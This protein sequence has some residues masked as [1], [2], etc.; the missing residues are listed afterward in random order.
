MRRCGT[1]RG[2]GR[3]LAQA[4]LEKVFRRATATASAS[5]LGVA[6]NLSKEVVEDFVSEFRGVV[7]VVDFDGGR[8][9]GATRVAMLVAMPLPGLAANQCFDAWR[10]LRVWRR[11]SRSE[12]AR[13]T[14][15]VVTRAKLSERPCDG[16][17]ADGGD[18]DVGD[19]GDD[20]DYD[21]VE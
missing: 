10:R 1:K 3:E 15:F 20:D 7:D 6:L 13:R 16:G 9:S 12:I 4:V 19:A 14:I 18:G 5:T 21:D 17:D 11:P 2:R 8:G